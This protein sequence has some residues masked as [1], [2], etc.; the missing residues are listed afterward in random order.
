MGMISARKGTPVNIQKTIPKPRVESWILVSDAAH[1]E[2]KPLPSRSPK[3]KA[4]E[5]QSLENAGSTELESLFPA[6][7]LPGSGSMGMISA[8]TVRHPNYD[9]NLK[10]FNRKY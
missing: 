8:C 9:A 5:D 6:P 2:I 10:H 3:Q 7:A 4:K 1:R